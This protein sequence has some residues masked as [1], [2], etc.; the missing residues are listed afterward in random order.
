[1][2]GL[3]VVITGAAKLCPILVRSSRMKLLLP[4]LIIVESFFTA[5]LI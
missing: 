1:V 5:G 4:W 3:V 2:V